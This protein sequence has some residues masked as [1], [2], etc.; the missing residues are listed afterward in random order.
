MPLPTLPTEL[1]FRIAVFLPTNHDILRLMLCCRRFRHELEHFLYSHREN[2][3]QLA[4]EWAVDAEGRVAT[5]C[6]IEKAGLDLRKSGKPL[7]HRAIEHASLDS[8][9]HLLDVSKFDIEGLADCEATGPTTPLFAAIVSGSLEGAELLLRHGANPASPGTADGGTFP[10]HRATYDRKKDIAKLLVS[11]G[12]SVLTVNS[13]GHTPLHYAALIGDIE[14]AEL[15]L[16]KGADI[17]ATEEYDNTPLSYVAS[18]DLNAEVLKLLLD[19]GAVVHQG[20]TEALIF[21]ATETGN[22]EV[23][24]VL[25]QHGVKID[26]EK[27]KS[28]R[29]ELLLHAAQAGTASK[30]ERLLKS[31][32]AVDTCTEHGATALQVACFYGSVDVAKLLLRAGA[33]PSC[34]D[35]DGN[36]AILA[37]QEPEIVA[38]LIEKGA[39]LNATDDDGKSPLSNAVNSGFWEI[40]KLLLAAGAKHCDQIEDDDEL[41]LHSSH[42]S[43]DP[44]EVKLLRQHGAVFS[45]TGATGLTPLY[46]AANAGRTRLVEELLQNGSDV[47]GVV[48]A[49]WSPLMAAASSDH[50]VTVQTLLRHGAELEYADEFGYTALLEAAE[51]GNQAT[52]MLLL[53]HGANAT[54]A[55]RSGSNALIMAAEL[56][57]EDLV[58][59]LLER[60]GID[61]DQVDYCGRSALMRASLRGRRTVVNRLLRNKILP[62]HSIKD[63]WGST[64]LTLAVRNGFTR[65]VKKLLG[66][67]NGKQALQEKDGFNRSALDW[68][69]LC[70]RS[71]ITSMLA[72]AAKV[73]GFDHAPGDDAPVVFRLESCYCDVCGRCSTCRP[74]EVTYECNS[75][76]AGGGGTFLICRF[77]AADGMSCTEAAHTW[78]R[79]VDCDCQGRK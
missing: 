20:F 6:L 37:S 57:H 73:K 10:L 72:D 46:I 3:L 50:L 17:H 40:S 34:S 7:L 16:E 71:Q 22:D 79:H 12:A 45:D 41:K 27:I 67:P 11:Y 9:R 78:V 8:I 25:L 15:F 52:V 42:R 2:G 28:D 35:V 38:M 33:N 47:N 44:R 66:L 53:L 60:S 70:G 43:G 75:C 30:I 13:T 51:Q 58:E 76:T 48:E 14:L 59:L 18:D 77:C 49:G 64:A 65:I 21:L 69:R 32:V 5:L 24:A 61:I 68:A 23:V 62:D 74:D 26:K 1:L 29:E 31:G 56:G 39:D 55:N 54:A 36:S 19:R 63:I 4:A